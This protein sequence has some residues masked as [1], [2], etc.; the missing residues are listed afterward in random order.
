MDYDVCDLRNDIEDLYSELRF[1]GFSDS[2]AHSIIDALGIIVKY[3]ERNK[4]NEN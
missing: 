3:L 2:Q 1:S 4:T